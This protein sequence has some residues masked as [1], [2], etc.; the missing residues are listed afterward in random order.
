MKKT[1]L[2][3]GAMLLVSLSFMAQ[4]DGVSFGPGTGNAPDSTGTG[5]FNPDSLGGG[6][7]G[8]NP[9]SLSGGGMTPPDS[10]GGGAGGFNPDSLGAGGMT[11]PDSLG[12]G[13]MQGGDMPGGG[14]MPGGT[15]S[16]VYPDGATYCLND[17]ISVTE[18]SQTYTNSSSDNNVVEVLWGNLTLNDCTLGKTG[19]TA[20]DGDNSS[21]YGVNSAL[22]VGP[23]DSTTYYA[24]CTMTGGTITTDAKGSNAAFATRGGVLNISGVTIHTTED[25]SRGLHATYGGHI[26]ASDMDITTEG[27]SC[28]TIATDRGGGYV[29]VTGG[30]ATAKGTNSAVLYSTGTIEATGLTGVSEVGEIAVVEGDNH[31]TMTNCTM[32]SGSSKRALMMLQSGSGD[33]NGYNAAINVYNSSLTVTD[34]GTPLCEVPTLNMGTLTLNDVSLSVASGLLMKVDYNTQWSTYGGTGRLV[35]ESATGTASNPWIYTGA[36]TADSYSYATVEVGANTLWYG[37]IDNASEAKGD[38]VT[39]TGTWVLDSDANVDKLVI[40]EGGRVVTN[41]HALTYSSI[42]NNGTLD[43]TTTGL[44]YDQTTG[45]T[46]VT[47]STSKQTDDAYYDLQGRKFTSVPSHGIYIHKGKKVVL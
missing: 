12:G 21:F 1:V 8:F 33:A 7:G 3:L 47:T 24:T 25:T 16:A 31:V 5:G 23:T 17:D 18:T 27:Q 40:N 28:S 9:D 2:T 29:Y 35:L 32:T 39:V 6:A 22:Y 41:G 30:S 36:V 42:S 44:T 20:S 38:T 11:P 43:T 26:N 14:Q 15:D 13:Q 46:S 4:G 37:T 10:L 19:D 45:I 34:A